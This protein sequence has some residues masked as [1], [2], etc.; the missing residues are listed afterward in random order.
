MGILKGNLV[1]DIEA[2]ILQ[3]APSDDSELEREQITQWVNDNLHD[4]VRREILGEQAK[5]KIIPP[6]YVFRENDLELQEETVSGIDNIKQRLFVELEN[7]VLDLPNDGG[8]VRVLDYDLNLILKTSV[9]QLESLRDMKYARPGVN[10]TLHYRQEKKI[11]IEGFNTADIDF[12]PIIADYVRKQDVLAMEDD[13][14][15]II[16]DQLIP[17]LRNLCIQQGKLQM[18]GTQVDKT[19]DGVDYKDPSYHLSIA[20]PV[21][22]QTPQ[23]QQ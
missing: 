16:T 9:E 4:L 5:G 12:N 19:N 22:A 6:I 8:L 17:V 21:A 7:E 18:Y 14:E 3:G 23:P 10:N 20:N 2:G 11:F 1:S 15:I 13:D